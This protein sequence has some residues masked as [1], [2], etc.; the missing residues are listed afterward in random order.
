MSDAW[1]QTY[2]VDSER[3]H[4]RLP[5][6]RLGGGVD[7]RV[8]PRWIVVVQPFMDH[9]CRYHFHLLIVIQYRQAGRT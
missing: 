1:G 4:G 2:H 9:G 8:A 6:A 3:S 5:D 7:D